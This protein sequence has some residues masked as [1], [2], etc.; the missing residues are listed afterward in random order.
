M[1]GNDETFGRR[2]FGRAQQQKQSKMKAAEEKARQEKE[3]A[4]LKREEEERKRAE[5]EEKA[6]NELESDHHGRI[7]IDYRQPKPSVF[8][9]SG[10]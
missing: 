10:E 5:E 1:T 4:K 3:E 2:V 8:P 6:Y 7:Y 9:V